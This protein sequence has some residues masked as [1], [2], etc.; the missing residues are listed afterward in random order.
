MESLI[1]GLDGIGK[2][3]SAAI[4]LILLTGATLIEFSWQCP[5]C[6][7]ITSGNM[8]KFIFMI[9]NHERLK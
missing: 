6:G 3:M 1:S 9:C 8:F 2:I 7:K 4:A 5:F